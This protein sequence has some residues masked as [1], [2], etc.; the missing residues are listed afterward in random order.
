MSQRNPLRSPSK[1]SNV[2][3]GASRIRS[4]PSSATATADDAMDSDA[5]HAAVDYH[6]NSPITTSPPRGKGAAHMV[7][8]PL[9]PRKGPTVVLGE[10]GPAAVY[11]EMP[12]APSKPKPGTRYFGLSVVELMSLP[13]H[14]DRDLP[15]IVVFLCEYLLTRASKIA[16]V[17][18]TACV[19][20]SVSLQPMSPSL[21]KYS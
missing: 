12:V 10:A 5:G 13:E 18:F 14:R 4:P 7:G 11:R 9:A 1:G 6:S 17:R 3:G 20:V 21:W 19:C 15:R 2:G 16:E 8:S